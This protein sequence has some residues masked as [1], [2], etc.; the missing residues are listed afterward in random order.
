MSREIG[1]DFA[2][3]FGERT[4]LARKCHVCKIEAG[5]KVTLLQEGC[6]ECFLEREAQ[7]LQGAIKGGAI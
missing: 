1:V 3:D 7:G 4:D 5:E 2:A 6:V